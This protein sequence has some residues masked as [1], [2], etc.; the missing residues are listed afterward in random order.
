MQIVAHH[1]ILARLSV[2]AAQIVGQYGVAFT[3]VEV[4]GVD[5]GERSA[6]SELMTAK[7]VLTTGAAIITA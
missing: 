1:R 2:H 5:D 6:S 4:I 3:A 7:G